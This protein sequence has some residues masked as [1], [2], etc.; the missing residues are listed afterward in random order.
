MTDKVAEKVAEK[1]TETTT[2]TV[3]II[4]Y[5]YIRSAF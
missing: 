4:T 3:M 1:V 5:S 2:E